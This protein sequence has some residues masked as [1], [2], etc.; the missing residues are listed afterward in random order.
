L[1]LRAAAGQPGAHNTRVHSTGKQDTRPQATGWGFLKADITAM[2]ANN[3]ARNGQSQPGAPRSAAVE[4]A[5]HLFTAFRC[6]A[7]PVIVN[8]DLNT[9]GGRLRHGE[10]QVLGVA[11]G[12]IDKIGDGAAD[13]ICA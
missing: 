4:R 7:R 8:E 5:K 3:V 2:G 1:V 6:D 13:G 10:R 9:S 12:I 11:A